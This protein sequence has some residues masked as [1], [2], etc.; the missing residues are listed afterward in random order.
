MKFTTIG[1]RQRQ[2]PPGR[3]EREVV[4]SSAVSGP[5]AAC[6]R[7]TGTAVGTAGITRREH[8]IQGAVDEMAGRSVNGSLVRVRARTR[9][10]MATCPAS[11]CRSAGERE[12]GVRDGINDGRRESFGLPKR[13]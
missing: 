8:R 3:D 5:T 4:G 10:S 1:G 2:G 6:R 11:Q 12:R 9:L 13:V 7:A